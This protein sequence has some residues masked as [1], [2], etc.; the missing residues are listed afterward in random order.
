LPHVADLWHAKEPCDYME[1]VGHFLP[2][3]LPSLIEDSAPA[4]RGTSLELT[5]GT[6]SG[7]QRACIRPRC[8]GAT[9]PQNQSTLS[10][11]SE[12]HFHTGNVNLGDGLILSRL[13]SLEEQEALQ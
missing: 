1:V 6:K 12:M 9:R 10:D 2:D 5:E 4:W 8:I 7:A 13:L 11:A 3:L